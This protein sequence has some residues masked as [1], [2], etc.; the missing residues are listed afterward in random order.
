MTAENGSSQAYKDRIL[1]I[2]EKK[3]RKDVPE[4][5]E[6]GLRNYWFPLALSSEVVADKPFA[7]T[8]LCEDLMIWRDSS[9]SPHIFVDSCPHRAVKLSEGHS[10]GDRFQCAYHGLEFDGSG[11]CV[12]IPW[13]GD[14]AEKCKVVRAQSYPAAEVGGFIWGYIADVEKFPPPPVEEALPWE[15]LRDD[16][17]TYVRR[18]DLWETNWLLAWDGSFD[19][20]HNAFLHADGVTLRR[21]GGREGMTYRMAAK[22]LPNGV[23]LQKLGADGQVQNDLA[24]GWMLPGMATLVALYAEGGPMVRRSW[25]FPMDLKRTHVMAGYSRLVRTPEERERWA[26]LF[27]TRVKPD[28]DKINSQDKAILLTQRGL[29]HVRSNEQLLNCDV[30]IARARRLLRDA[31][32]AHREGRRPEVSLRCPLQTDPWDAHLQRLEAR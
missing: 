22:E 6:Y 19:P 7:V 29:A 11:R 21:F 14:D 31:F 12:Y 8:A 20:Q 9:G 30:G 28:S 3:W 10:L 26:H 13:E 32:L 27:H 2:S 15:L 1:G 17:I 24:G 25:R 18:Q 5:L 4:G 23:K 16:C